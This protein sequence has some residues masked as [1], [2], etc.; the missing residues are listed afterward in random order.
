[1]STFVD[2]RRAFEAAE[3]IEAAAVII[4]VK[5][6]GMDGFEL[7][8]RLRRTAT[9]GGIPILMLTSAGKQQEVVRAF[10]LGASDHMSK[11]FAAAELV[12]R[13]RRLIRGHAAIP[14]R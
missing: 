11:P 1:M 10:E 14:R 8:E 5:L 12:A 7:L 3:S 13:V 4:D 6:P 2:G 9:Y